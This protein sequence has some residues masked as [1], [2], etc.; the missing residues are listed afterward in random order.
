MQ[1]QRIALLAILI[2]TTA[3]KSPTSATVYC[4]SILRLHPRADTHL[5]KRSSLHTSHSHRHSLFGSSH[6]PGDAQGGAVKA[7]TRDDVYGGTDWT[8]LLAGST[9]QPL[10]LHR[11]LAHH[12]FGHVAASCAEPLGTTAVILSH[13]QPQQYVYL[14]GGCGS[15]QLP[16]TLQRQGRSA[17][18]QRSHQLDSH[19]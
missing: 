12:L 18:L 9:P 3:A 2:P 13:P 11:P 7:R 19:L 14:T 15:A 16:R 10:P 17:L 5:A 6:A 4:Y 8:A 1:K